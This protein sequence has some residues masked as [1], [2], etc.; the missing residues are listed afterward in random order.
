MLLFRGA[1][2]FN[3]C[4]AYFINSNIYPSVSFTLSIVEVN[5]K[6]VKVWEPSPGKVVIKVLPDFVYVPDWLVAIHE[7][8]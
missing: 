6:M 8:L 4:W 7:E 1:F 3:D 2:L 5:C